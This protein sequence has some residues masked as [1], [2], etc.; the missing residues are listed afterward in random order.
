VH[1][2]LRLSSATLLSANLVPLAGVFLL[3]WS[4]S[5]VMGA[6]AVAAGRASSPG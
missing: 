4:V 5:S 6:R 3:D 1:N 2:R